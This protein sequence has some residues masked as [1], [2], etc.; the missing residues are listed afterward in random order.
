M[1]PD[2]E[3]RPPSWEPG[4]LDHG[5]SGSR[6]LS[7][8]S[9]SAP[10]AQPLSHARRLAEAAFARVTRPFTVERKPRWRQ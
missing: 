9:K 7:R 6:L 3:A 8:D 5:C 4:G 1:P 2:K 10:A